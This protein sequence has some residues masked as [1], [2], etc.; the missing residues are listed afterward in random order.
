MS[1]TRHGY[2]I[3][4]STGA[5]DLPKIKRELTVKPNIPS[6]FVQPQHVKRYP[7]YSE[8]ENFLSVPKQFGLRRLT[9]R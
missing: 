1:V 7:V 3:L 6:V 8:T 2:K 5:L 4:K 9:S